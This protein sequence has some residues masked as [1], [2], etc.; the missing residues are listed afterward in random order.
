M[1]SVEGE[2]RLKEPICVIHWR[3]SHREREGCSRSSATEPMMRLEDWIWARG[4]RDED[5]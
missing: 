4:R 3:S 2:G 5:L 1:E